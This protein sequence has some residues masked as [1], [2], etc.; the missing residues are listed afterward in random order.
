MAGHSPAPDGQQ[1]RGRPSHVSVA[2]RLFRLLGPV[3]ALHERR[4]SILPFLFHQLYC[5]KKCPA[6][7]EY[8]LGNLCECIRIGKIQST[9]NNR[10][11]FKFFR[12]NKS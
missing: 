5:S 2:G 1:G 12:F 7:A 8:E 9:E 3:G 10:S 6:S 11:I 4:V